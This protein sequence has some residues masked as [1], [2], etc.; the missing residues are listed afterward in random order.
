MSTDNQSRIGMKYRKL[1]VTT[2]RAV[3][4]SRQRRGDTQTI[5]NALG[6]NKVYVGNVINGHYPNE[7]IINHA[8]NMVRGRKKNSEV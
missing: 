3:I 5:A 8:Y 6:Y 1:N 7:R 2:K 4:K